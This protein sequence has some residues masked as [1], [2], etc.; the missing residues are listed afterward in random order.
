MTFGLVIV[1][2]TTTAQDRFVCLDSSV[3]ESKLSYHPSVALD[4]IYSIAQLAFLHFWTSRFVYFWSL[5]V[6]QM[7]CF[8]TKR[9]TEK[10]SLQPSIYH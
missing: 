8:R 1:V 2:I 10:E 3:S 6:F 5:D 4:I 9:Y 7:R